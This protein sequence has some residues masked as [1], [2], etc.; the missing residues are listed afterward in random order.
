MPGAPDL[1]NRG[2]IDGAVDGV[3]DGAV[4]GAINGAINGAIGAYLV[5]R[6]R[7]PRS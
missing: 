6:R 3:I 4:D 2:V 5:S 7:R 1:D